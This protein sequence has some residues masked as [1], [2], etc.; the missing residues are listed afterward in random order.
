[1]ENIRR[2][3]VVGGDDGEK[4]EKACFDLCGLGRVGI[5]ADATRCM[6]VYL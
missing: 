1:M 2:K 5:L 6:C 3:E 4:K